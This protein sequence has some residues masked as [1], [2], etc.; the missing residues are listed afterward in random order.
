MTARR[1][2]ILFVCLGNICRS[3]LAEAAFRREAERAGL[4]VEVDSAGTGPWHV[5]EPPD[6]RAQETARRHGIDISGYR[7]R[8]VGRADF[9]RF[10]H[11]VALDRDNLAVLE[12]MR[13]E[14]GA[15]L[16]LLLDHVPGRAGEAVADP[17]YGADAAF[18]ET[19]AD[20]SAGARA[21]VALLA[22]R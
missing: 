21:L 17:Y 6:R 3:P 4:D 18:D 20:V 15:A 11:V 22:R 9:A 12:R 19:W 1:P 2:A 8:Q 10:T 7:G 13:P 5:D 14:G 16:S